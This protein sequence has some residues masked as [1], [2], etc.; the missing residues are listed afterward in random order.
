M[1]KIA[2]AFKYKNRVVK[3][4]WTESIPDKVFGNIKNNFCNQVGINDT[5]YLGVLRKFEKYVD[6]YYNSIKEEE[7]LPFDDETWFPEE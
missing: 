1:K 4:W 3:I 6:D 7:P 2:Q 5:S